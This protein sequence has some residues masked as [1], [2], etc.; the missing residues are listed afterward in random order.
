LFTYQIKIEIKPYKR[1]EFNETMRLLTRKMAKEKDCLGYSF[2]RDIE[3]EN[4]YN[5][6]GEWKT[7][8]AMKNHF[9]TQDFEVLIGVIKVLDEKFT[10]KI[11]E[12]SKTG[13]YELARELI[14][15]QLS[16]S[17]ASD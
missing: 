10:M 2:Y 16:Q 12:V 9:K 3:M 17:T 4:N 5:V 6:I 11:A 15:S 7:R 8:Q 1:G 13:S 14:T